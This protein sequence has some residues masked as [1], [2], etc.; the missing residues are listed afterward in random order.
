MSNLEQ[1][2]LY[3]A[4]WLDETFVDGNYLKTNIINRMP[5]LNQFTFS[6]NSLTLFN[7]ELN[8]PS[9]EDIQC[10]FIDFPIHAI[11]SYVDYFFDAGKGR[12]HIYSY[13]SLMEYYND[14]SDSFRGVLFASKYCILCGKSFFVILLFYEIFKLSF[15]QEI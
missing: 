9:T 2:S 14:I 12:C 1:L 7:N 3:I 15:I 4:I 11:I 5:R 10:T 6:I 13:P 8:L